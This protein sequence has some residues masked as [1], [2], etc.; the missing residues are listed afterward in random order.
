MILLDTFA[1]HGYVWNILATIDGEV[2]LEQG[3]LDIWGDQVYFMGYAAEELNE[4]H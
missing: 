2:Y 4:S 3:D 1:I